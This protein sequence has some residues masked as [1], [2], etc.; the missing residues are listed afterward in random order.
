[1]IH[2]FIAHSIE[3]LAFNQ[4]LSRARECKGPGAR[5]TPITGH[6]HREK[7]TDRF[8]AL[9]PFMGEGEPVYPF[10]IYTRIVTCNVFHLP[11]SNIRYKH[12]SRLTKSFKCVR[13]NPS[14]YS[15]NTR[16]LL[17]FLF[18]EG[19]VSLVTFVFQRCETDVFL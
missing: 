2:E 19:R 5:E 12:R 18:S 1:M 9:N 16:A 10:C 8:E 17:P 3:C 7:R 14:V 6:C 4:E 13:N 11:E 15:F